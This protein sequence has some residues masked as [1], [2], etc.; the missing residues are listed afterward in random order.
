MMVDVITVLCRAAL[1][2]ISAGLFGTVVS[3]QETES[4]AGRFTGEVSVEVVTVDVVVTDKKGN[5]VLGL[6]RGDF[7][8]FEDGTEVEITNYLAVGSGMPATRGDESQDDSTVERLP[9]SAAIVSPPTA[10]D[11][12]LVVY[13]DHVFLFTQSTRRL[14]PRLAEF[15][16]DQV[17]SG[18][19][20][21]L[22]AY[23]GSIKIRVGFTENVE[24]VITALDAE[25]MVAGRGNL[26]ASEGYMTFHTWAVAEDAALSGGTGGPVSPAEAL[27][28]VQA[29]RQYAY[30]VLAED[31]RALIR[32]DWR[33]LRYF[34]DSFA[35]LPGRKV[36]LHVS[37]GVPVRPDFWDDPSGSMRSPGSRASVSPAVTPELADVIAHASTLGVTIHT[38]YGEGGNRGSTSGTAISPEVAG[39]AARGRSGSNPG[40]A[41][42]HRSQQHRIAGSPG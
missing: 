17:P 3:A 33:N 25:M 40:D 36:L 6:E 4:P 20:V 11:R 41:V 29:Q 28:D 39:R 42:Q 14:V 9:E 23:D 26:R 32:R 34:I 8:I 7:K 12:Y 30:D 2:L 24:Q 31:Y 13:L 1:V 21:M 22:A 18:T 38:V 35:G 15:L 5:P 37:D 10:G 16:R 19:R 27:A